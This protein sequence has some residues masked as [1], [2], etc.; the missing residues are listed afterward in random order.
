MSDYKNCPYCGEE[1]L[2]EAKKCR[3]CGEWLS[4][5][6]D[7]PSNGNAD[8]V[9][10]KNEK[11]RNE[12]ELAREPQP[13]VNNQQQPI[14]H[15]YTTAA[16]E[17]NKN[18]LGLAGFILSLVSLVLSWLPGVNWITWILGLIFSAI[19]VFKKPRGFAIA[20]LAISLISLVVILIVIAAFAETASEIASNLK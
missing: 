17:S 20:G 12:S 1:I 8:T 9:A 3:H 19:G 2:A 7:N 6:T 10:V 4:D 15:V 5:K 18:G 13:V 14:V 11:A 16:Q